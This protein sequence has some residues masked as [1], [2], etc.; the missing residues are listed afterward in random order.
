M[1]PLLSWDSVHNDNFSAT[2]RYTRS[3][4]NEYPRKNRGTI[5]NGNCFYICRNITTR[6]IESDCSVVRSIIQQATAWAQKLN[7]LYCWELLPS[8][9]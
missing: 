6:K 3:R 7:N 4:V 2:A 5:W 8:N 1:D 9:D